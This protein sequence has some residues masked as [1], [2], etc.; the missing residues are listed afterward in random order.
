[1]TRTLH[2]AA[3]G[4]ATRGGAVYALVL[5]WDGDEHGRLVRR[6]LRH[7]QGPAAHR[8]VLHALWEAHRNRARA[9]VVRSDDAALVAQ[10][11]GK[12]APS[13]ALPHYLQIRTMM[14]AFAAAHVC[15]ADPAGDADMRAAFDA[16]AAIAPRR[17][18]DLPLWV[19]AAS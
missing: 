2:V 5:R 19:A 17:Y 16:V 8:A 10:L 18:A 13:E 12:D 9:V 15:H 14:N 1:V 4:R 11:A 7:A 6:R 3:S